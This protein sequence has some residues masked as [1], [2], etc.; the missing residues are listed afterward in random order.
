ML[1]GVL[2]FVPGGIFSY[3]GAPLCSFFPKRSLAVTHEMLS[4]FIP[5]CTVVVVRG[6]CVFELRDFFFFFF[7]LM[8]I[9]VNRKDIGYYK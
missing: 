7:K 4:I 8:V 2:A 3:K 5:C 1:L 6:C 9:K